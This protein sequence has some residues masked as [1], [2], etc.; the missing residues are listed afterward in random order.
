MTTITYNFANG[1]KQSQ[2][3]NVG[4]TYFN[5][6][7]RN[8]NG[9]MGA[10]RPIEELFAETAHDLGAV[11]YTIDGEGA[12]NTEVTIKEQHFTKEERNYARKEHKRMKKHETSTFVDMKNKLQN[13]ITDTFM[14][15]KR[16][17]FNLAGISFDKRMN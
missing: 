8:K 4:E 9:K 3:I 12:N 2:T 17:K 5:P 10:N 13:E 15:A 6:D 1:A 11:S 7:F 14:S 16:L